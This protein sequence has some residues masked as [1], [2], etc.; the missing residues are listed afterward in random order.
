MILA[1]WGTE[2]P[3]RRLS[4]GM[5]STGPPA[6]R[7]SCTR[8]RKPYSSW[9]LSFTRTFLSYESQLQLGRLGHPALVP[10]RVQLDLYVGFL[11]PGQGQDLALDVL[12]QDVAHPAAGGRER[13]AH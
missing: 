9:E 3:S 6:W 4:S 1:T 7:P 11:H 5:V 8:Q 12:A 2:I 13:E 10:G